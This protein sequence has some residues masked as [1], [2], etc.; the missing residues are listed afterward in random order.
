ALK[1]GDKFKA[2]VISMAKAAVLQA[3]KVDGKTLDDEKIIEV[4]SREVKQRREALI[5]FEKGNRQDLVDE[6]KAQI[7]IIMGYLPQQL[8]EDEILHIIQNAAVEVGANS[9]KDM[10]KL[11][12]VVMK[13]TRGRAEGKLVSDLVK[14]YLNK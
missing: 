11:M 4:L 9:M 3:E 12:P 13:A 1:A 7:E 10:S 8:T 6:A 5:E 2:N 14:D